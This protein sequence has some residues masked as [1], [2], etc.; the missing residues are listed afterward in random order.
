MPAYKQDSEVH[1]LALTTFDFADKVLEKTGAALTAG[2]LAMEVQA[3][4]TPVAVALMTRAKIPNNDDWEDGNIQVDVPI[5]VANINCE[6]DVRAHRCNSAGVI[7]ESSSYTS[8]QIAG[9][10]GVLLFSIADAPTS[11]AAGAI[12][13]LLMIEIRNNRVSGGSGA[14]SITI[15]LGENEGRGTNDVST[16]ISEGTQAFRTINNIKAFSETSNLETEV[17]TKRSMT[18]IK[19]DEFDVS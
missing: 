17:T 11:W 8:K 14:Q 16:L 10:T 4:G 5:N 13:D 7:Q 19:K 12:G 15:G 18:A 3:G 9:S 6:V 2:T 1:P